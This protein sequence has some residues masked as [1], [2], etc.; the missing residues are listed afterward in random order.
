MKGKTLMQ[1]RILILFCELQ[2][3][4]KILKKSKICHNAVKIIYYKFISN[5]QRKNLK[6]IKHSFIAL[7]I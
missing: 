4:A 7:N 5:T 3:P 6:R 2:N 1:N